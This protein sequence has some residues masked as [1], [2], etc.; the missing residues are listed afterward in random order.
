MG[1]EEGSRGNSG[2]S[3]QLQGGGGR[4]GQEAQGSLARLCTWAGGPSGQTAGGRCT[5]VSLP[6]TWGCEVL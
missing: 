2:S 4:G 6:W 5:L 3:E 1:D